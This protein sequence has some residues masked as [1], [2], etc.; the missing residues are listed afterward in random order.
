MAHFIPPQPGRPF[1]LVESEG[2]ASVVQVDPALV[3]AQYQ[4]HGALLF[5]GFATD[6]D[7][8]YAF[9]KHYCQ[10]SVVNESPGRALLDPAHAIYS[11]DGGTGAFSLHPELSRE[12]WK[13]DLALFGCLSAPSTGG[14]TTLCDGIA[15]VKAMPPV[16][17][18]GLADRRLLYIK[19][20]WPELLDYWLGSTA[21]DDALLRNPPA[22][23]PY[24]FMR[25][26]DGR[27]A[28]HFSRPA[29]HKPMFSDEPAFG[30]FLLFARFNNGRIGFPL[31]DDFSP[32]PD[33]WLRAIRD[34]G[35]DLSTAVAWRKGD[36][37]MLDNTRFMHGRTAITD[38]QQRQ[39]ATYFGYLTGAVPDPEEPKNAI[40]RREDFEPPRPPDYLLR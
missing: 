14:Q 23:C 33:D 27:I 39:I 29:L 5:R 8:F 26:N 21:P 19:T 17:R 24:R 25:L 15:L 38:P 30:N 20:S 35:D 36:V 9:A 16:V 31:L 2:E 13:P 7:Q 40:W 28:R 1:V 32:V 37:L 3:L 12:P 10:T 11:V 6:L 4:R 34:T 22:D 18:S